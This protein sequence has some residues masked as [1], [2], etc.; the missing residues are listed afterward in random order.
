MEVYNPV[1]T[2][3]VAYPEWFVAEILRT[4]WPAHPGICPVRG[5]RAGRFA[6]ARNL[7]QKNHLFQEKQVVF[8]LISDNQGIK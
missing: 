1:A 2:A 6:S 8:F 4:V 5:E 3:D 7:A